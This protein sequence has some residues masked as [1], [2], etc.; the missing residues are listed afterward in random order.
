M[1]HIFDYK[2]IPGDETGNLPYSR[3]RKMLLES[4]KDGYYTGAVDAHT[5]Q[6]DVVWQEDGYHLKDSSMEPSC[7]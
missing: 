5:G 6:I 1:Q 4:F 7:S 3:L 2:P